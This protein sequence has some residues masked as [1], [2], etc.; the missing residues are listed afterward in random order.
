MYGMFVFLIVFIYFLYVELLNI[1]WKDNYRLLNVLVLLV[2]VLGDIVIY[3]FL[4]SYIGLVCY[5]CR[6]DVFL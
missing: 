2:V 4:Y 3:V 6:N 1:I 5:V